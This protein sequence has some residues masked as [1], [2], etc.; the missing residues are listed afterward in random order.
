MHSK[1]KNT[2][3]LHE[4]INEFKKG[5]QPRTNLV[6]DESSDCRVHSQYILSRWK[7]CFS[8]LLNVYR[9]CDVRHMEM[10]AAEP[11]VPEPSPFEAEIAVT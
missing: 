3:D 8:Q 6:K 4:G 1:N 2:R 10:Y 7:N 5:Y 11:L 9:V